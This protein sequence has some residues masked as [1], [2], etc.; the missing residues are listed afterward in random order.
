MRVNPALCVAL[1]LTALAP[2][3]TTLAEPLSA[4][5]LVDLKSVTAVALAPAGDRVAYALHPGS[6]VVRRRMPAERLVRLP[7]GVDERTA[8]AVM[9]KGLT[10]HYL[11]RRTYAVKPGDTVYIG[12]QE[13][14]WEE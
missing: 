13:L 8:A 11:L 3:G 7:D 9:L 5:M 6:Y 4:E 1:L 10:A 14:V 2:S 12:D